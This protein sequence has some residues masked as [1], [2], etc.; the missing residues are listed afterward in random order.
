MMGELPA[1]RVTPYETPFTFTG[2]DIFG[3][4]HVKRG[5][6]SQKIYGCIFICF[7][8]RAIHIEDVSSLETDSFIQ[9]LRRFIALRDAA[10]EIW[11]D[12]GTNLI[13]GETLREMLRTL[14]ANVAGILNTR[15]LCSSNDDPNDFEAL[16]PSH[17]LQQRQGLA[18]PPGIF[19]DSEISSRKQWKR[20]QVLAN[21][22]WARWI[23]EYL[24]LLLARR[25]WLTLKRNL[26]VD[27]LVL[28]VDAVQPRSHWSLGR[29]TKV[30]PGK[31][32]LVRTAEVT[33][34]SSVSV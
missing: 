19:Q 4:F 22:F 28:V 14:V 31:D 11:S 33:T 9:A 5:R 25:K 2:L 3:P 17:F 30:F 21:H 32:G 7:V 10:K 13:G 8:T 29:V 27:D 26:K 12:N 16:T 1:S 20:A 15:P 18:I 6:G 24:P 34:K 23:R